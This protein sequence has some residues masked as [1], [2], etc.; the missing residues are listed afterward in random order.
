[1]LNMCIYIYI[2]VYFSL[3]KH[4]Y[5]LKRIVYIW[6]SLKLI[7]LRKRLTKSSLTNVLRSQACLNQ[8]PIQHFPNQSPDQCTCN[9]QV[10]TS[11]ENDLQDYTLHS[12]FPYIKLCHI[13]YL[14]LQPSIKKP[15]SLC[16]RILPQCSYW[17]EYSPGCFQ[18]FIA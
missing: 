10:I 17:N 11:K 18:G 2:Q 9:T 1:M 7:F 15:Y 14:C 4:H 13:K 3:Q 8:S 5:Q 16:S 12:P 6:S